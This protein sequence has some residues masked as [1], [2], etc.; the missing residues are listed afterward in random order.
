VRLSRLRVPAVWLLAGLVLWLARPS[1]PWLAVGAGL[2]LLG[3]AIRLWA[4][5]HIDK[6][7]ALAT[8]GPYW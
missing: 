4:S 5:G 2:A 3:E 7:R 8:G 6:T 1:L